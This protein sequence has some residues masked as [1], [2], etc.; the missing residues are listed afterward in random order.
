VQAFNRHGTPSLGVASGAG[1]QQAWHT[2]TRCSFRCGLSI[3]P[4]SCR[5]SVG[6][7]HFRQVW[8]LVLIVFVTSMVSGVNVLSGSKDEAT[9]MMK[10][11]SNKAAQASDRAVQV[12][13]FSPTGLA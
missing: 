8:L 2:L 12:S 9:W 10:C 13:G 11:A 5:I 7:A 3:G 6:L 1:F 4:T